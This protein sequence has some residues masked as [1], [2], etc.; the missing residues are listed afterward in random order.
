MKMEG[1]NLSESDSI[2]CR[3]YIAFLLLLV[4]VTMYILLMKMEWNPVGV[5]Y[6]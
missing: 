2:T 4:M 6:M 1:R 5:S 3:I